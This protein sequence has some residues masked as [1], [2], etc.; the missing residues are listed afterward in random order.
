MPERVYFCFCGDNCKFE[1]MTKEQ[2]IT[3]IYEAALYGQIQNIDDGFITKV[4]EQNKGETLTFWLGTTAEF[5]AIEEE[6]P[7]CF[8]IKTDDT[9]LEDMAKEIE[10]IKEATEKRLDALSEEIRKSR[11]YGDMDSFTA[12]K[13]PLYGYITGN[14]SVLTF[15]LPL[16]K[17][18]IVDNVIVNTLDFYVAGVQGQFGGL[19]QA[20]TDI[21]Y[22]IET[23]IVENGIK[24]TVHNTTGAFSNTVDGTPIAI[25]ASAIDILFTQSEN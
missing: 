24:F 2:I 1:T 21:N 17:T 4:K 23:A 3:A 11:V 25:N 8:Y 13:L 15:L 16:S 12:S 19:I 20:A 7:K 22:F 18:V 5:N 6:D 10:A 9:T 14:C